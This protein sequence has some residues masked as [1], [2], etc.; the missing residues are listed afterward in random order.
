MLYYDQRC[1]GELLF[2]AH[3]DLIVRDLINLNLA[4][5][6]LLVFGRD[7]KPLQ[8]QSGSTAHPESKESE[9]ISINLR[10]YLARLDR[11]PII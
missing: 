11:S 8:K 5:D 9:C 10:Y 2:L 4:I 3:K 7:R 1:L 6:T